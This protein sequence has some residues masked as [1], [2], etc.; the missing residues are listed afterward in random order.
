MMRLSAIRIPS[1]DL[2]AAEIFYAEALGLEKISGAPAMGYVQFRTGG[3]DLILEPEEAGDF[4]AGR[5]L[6]LSFRVDDIE[7]AIGELQASGVGITGIPEKQS[8]GGTLAHFLDP[9]GNVVTL[10]QPP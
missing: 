4:E 5:F 3:I 10:V 2:Q 7:T 9:S 1:T 8:W 6:G